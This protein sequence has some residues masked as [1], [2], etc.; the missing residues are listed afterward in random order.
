MRVEIADAGF[1]GLELA[2]LLSEGATDQVDV[3]LIDKADSFVFGYSKLGVM[4][5]RRTP[6]AVRLP[7]AAIDKP[8]VRFVRETVRSIDPHE[9][10]HTTDAGE[11]SRARRAGRHR[12]RAGRLSLA[13]PHGDLTV[14]EPPGDPLVHVRD[15]ARHADLAT[16]Q[17]YVHRIAAEKVTTA[18]GEALAG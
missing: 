7:Y 16:T 18:I 15:F 4:F 5:G 13:A 11:H 17:G 3:V 2:T 8:G 6:D 12:G 9:R 10:R 1:G 14:G